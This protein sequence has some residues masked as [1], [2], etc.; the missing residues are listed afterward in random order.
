MENKIEKILNHYRERF[1]PTEF[2]LPR[3]LIDFFESLIKEN[4][5]SMENILNAIDLTYYELPPDSSTNIKEIVKKIKTNIEYLKK[6]F[7]AE[8]EVNSTNTIQTVHPPSPETP[9][10]EPKKEQDNKEREQ[11]RPIWMN[12][13]SEY[14]IP[15]SVIPQKELASIPINLRDFYISNKVSDYLYSKMSKEERENLEKIIK[16][17]LSRLRLYSPQEREE[18]ERLLRRYF[19]KKLY[20][21]PF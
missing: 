9:P 17:R 18:A 6:T 14:G 11:G 15:K 21:I 19:I 1:R 10:D 16:S 2:S 8:L 12:L 5:E 3:V 13:F 20:S 4:P 7:D